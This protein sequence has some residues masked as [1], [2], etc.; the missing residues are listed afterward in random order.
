MQVFQQRIHQRLTVGHDRILCRRTFGQNLHVAD[1]DLDTNRI[2]EVM[3][4]HHMALTAEL[5][6]IHLPLGLVLRD[7]QSHGDTGIHLHDLRRQ[8]MML[9]VESLQSLTGQTA[10]HQD[11]RQVLLCLGNRRRHIELFHR[12]AGTDTTLTEQAAGA[13]F[14]RRRVEA[15]FH[16]IIDI[17]DLEGNIIPL[18]L[19]AGAVGLN[20]HAGQK[21]YH[22]R[23]TAVH[24]DG[25]LHITVADIQTGDHLHNVVHKFTLLYS[26][27]SMSKS[28]ID[29]ADNG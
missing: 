8:R 9:F 25:T 17:V 1:Q 20:G 21:I 4:G 29:A 2:L 3:D 13:G 14:N 6:D 16:R 11:T 5:L 28:P 7:G 19:Q 22:R 27:S 15:G 10:Q 24:L 12:L 18:H 26:S 23:F